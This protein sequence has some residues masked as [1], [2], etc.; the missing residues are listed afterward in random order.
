MKRFALN[1]TMRTFAQAAVGNV[2]PAADIRALSQH[3][4][5]QAKTR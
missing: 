5:P 1:A 4:K 2:L 3:E